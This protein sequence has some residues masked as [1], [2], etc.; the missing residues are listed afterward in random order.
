MRKETNDEL[1]IRMK[2]IIIINWLSSSKIIHTHL[3]WS[4]N[5]HVA[6]PI[7]KIL[8]ATNVFRGEGIQNPTSCWVIYEH[9]IR[10]ACNSS[11]FPLQITTWLEWIDHIQILNSK[12]ATQYY[13]THSNH[14]H[15]VQYNILTSND[16]MTNDRMA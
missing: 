7:S 5:G 10:I 2:C 12:Q 14:S 1:S 9:F 4:M 15:S 6:Y 11:Q 8:Y 13:I 3:T 16:L